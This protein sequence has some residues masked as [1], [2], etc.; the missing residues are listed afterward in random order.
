MT[1]NSDS[2]ITY[3]RIIRCSQPPAP[4]D[5]RWV[6]CATASKLSLRTTVQFA[7]AQ[8]QSSSIREAI[9]SKHCQQ[10]Y[11]CSSMSTS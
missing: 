9:Y 11:V 4:N 6:V 8:P 10:S 1:R 3:N 2:S 7:N 5:I